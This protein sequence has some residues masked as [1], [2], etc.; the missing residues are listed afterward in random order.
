MCKYISP[1]DTKTEFVILMHPKEFKK[2]KN[3]TGR[4]THLSLKNS[5]LIIGASFAQNRRVNELIDDKDTECYVL[6]PSQDAINLNA[7]DS[8][9]VSKKNV[10]FIIDSTWACSKSMF[11]LSP[12]LRALKKISFTHDKTSLYEIKK[13]PQE[14]YLSTIESTLCVLELLN[15]NGYEEIKQDSF[16]TFL[17]PFKKMIEYQLECVRSENRVI[18]YRK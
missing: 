13:Q 14:N 8:L 7:K 3:N 17:E 5:Q 16:A 12:N 4:F 9:H 2:T 15:K 18:R 11:R 6:Y 1:I 10:I